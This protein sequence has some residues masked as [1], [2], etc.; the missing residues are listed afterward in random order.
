M[1][2]G[3]LRRTASRFFL[4]AMAAC[5][6]A[7]P[8]HAAG[9]F[10]VS[11]AS[12]AE[13]PDG[14]SWD[15][16]FKT[17]QE[18]ADA[19]DAAGGGEVWV[20]EGTYTA[21]TDPVLTMK[22]GV[23]LFGGFCTSETEFSTRDWNANP[24][25]IDGQYARRCVLG[26]N[27]TV[28]DGFT[29]TRGYA[30]AVPGQIASSGSGLMIL[31]VS[32]TVRNCAFVDNRADSGGGAMFNASGNLRVEHSTFQANRVLGSSIAYSNDGGGAIN[33]SSGS[34]T[35][36]GC[37]FT[38][39][40]CVKN[41]GALSSYASSTNLTN[42]VFSSNAAKGSGG[43]IANDYDSG[44]DRSVTNCTFSGNS[45]GGAGGAI[46]EVYP[47]T[48]T[49]SIFWND[50]ASYGYPE[51]ACYES[52]YDPTAVSCSCV[53]GGYAGTG[54][55]STDPL[56]IDD[57]G[58]SVQLRPGSPCV[59]AG[60]ADGAPTTDILGRPRPAGTG[61]D[62]G[63]YEGTVAPA[64]IVTLTNIRTTSDIAVGD[65]VIAA[66]SRLGT[67]IDLSRVITQELAKYTSDAGNH[68]H[69]EVGP[70]PAASLLL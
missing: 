54:N 67:V 12:T 31:N 20:A 38:A 40:T 26:A 3:M 45:A 27:D 36:Q 34:I 69:L 35:L 15:R 1:V 28:L 24:T 55:I 50:Q 52:A 18:G 41:G 62:M 59:D 60:I 49:N 6:C 39:N 9:V 65:Q 19:A 37:V 53:Q 70:A 13:T 7:C 17:L 51:I 5:L 66:R 33:T 21:A 30:V 42:C 56:L 58:G 4:L 10:R 11:A 29:V 63:A 22:A 2:N 14:S 8:A 16:A 25:V 61:V 23:S 48:I 68:V 43:A 47:S 57:S 46:L 44:R 64:D 32:L